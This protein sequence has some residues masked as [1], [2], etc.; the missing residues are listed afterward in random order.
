MINICTALPPIF[1]REIWKA[2][3]NMLTGMVSNVHYQT[4]PVI[5]GEPGTN[6]QHAFYQLIHQGTL[7]PLRFY[8]S[9]YQP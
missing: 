8:C 9:C 7:D 2:M 6:G 4:G 3:A 1:N 5:W